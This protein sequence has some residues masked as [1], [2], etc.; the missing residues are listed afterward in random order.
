MPNPQKRQ[1]AHQNRPDDPLEACL[2][3]WATARLSPERLVHTQGV[4][5]TAARL[6][7]Q[8]F[9]GHVASLRLAGWVHDAAKDLPDDD[10]LR[11]AA[12]LGY[13]ARPIE[14]QVPQLLHG[15]V[16]A[17]LAREECGLKDPIAMSAAAYHTTGH[18]AMSTAD[19]VFYLADLIEPSRDFSWVAQARVLAGQDLER[20][21][22]FALTCQLR[23]LLKRGAIIDARSVE[24]RNRLLLDGVILVPRDKKA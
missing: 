11:L 9:I 5:E 1:P 4:V 19:K 16:G 12:A 15:V 20:A 13:K 22:L 6:A 7:E 18:P 8:H 10:L 24:L 21:L 23:R 2:R 14:R 3:A 17:L